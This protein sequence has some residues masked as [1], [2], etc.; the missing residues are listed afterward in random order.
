MNGHRHDQ[1]EMNDFEAR[2]R[3]LI[4]RPPLAAEPLVEEAAETIQVAGGR[5]W[6][7]TSTET[8][9]AYYRTIGLSASCG[10][11]FGAAC[12]LLILHWSEV[13]SPDAVPTVAVAFNDTAA[14]S[15]SKQDSVV[16]PGDD[17]SIVQ[18]ESQ[19]RN[20]RLPMTSGSGFPHDWSND[21][22]SLG[23]GTLQVGSRLVSRQANRLHGT[24]NESTFESARMSSDEPPEIIAEASDYSS[25]VERGSQPLPQRQW[26]RQ[27]LNSPNEFF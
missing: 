24:R 13:P 2:L 21:L 12:T 5:R 10:A 17:S 14:V 4:P 15:E 8:S 23:P 9:R 20:P 27:M 16:E 22:R 7:S 19:P 25:R 6:W 3:A 1:T 18:V 11:L 26:M